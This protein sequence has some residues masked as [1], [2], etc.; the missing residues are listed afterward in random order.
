ME[1]EYLLLI[2]ATVLVLIAG[3][4]VGRK[5]T[6]EKS[7][8]RDLKGLVALHKNKGRDA[9][10]RLIGTGPNGFYHIPLDMR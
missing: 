8:N 10:L 7:I 4:V 3:A 6:K 9:P 2:G 1:V 5:K